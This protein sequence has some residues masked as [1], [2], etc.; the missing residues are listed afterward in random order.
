MSS[1]RHFAAILVTQ[2]VCVAV[3][4]VFH[5][6]LLARIGHGETGSS[7][8]P[9]SALWAAS[10]I[11]LVWTVGLLAATLFMTVTRLKP[12]NSA[13]RVNPEIEA[14]KQ[15]QALLRTQETVIFGLAKLS[16]SRDPETGRHLERI[17]Q[18]SS[19][20]AAALRQR[21]EFRDRITPGFLQLIGISSALHDIG[22]VGVEDSILRKPGAL[23]AEQR[24]RMQLHTQVG[25][26]CLKEIERQLGSTNFLQMACEIVSAHHEWW[27]G[28][29]YPRG[30]AGEEIPLSARIV[31][32]ADVYDALRSKRV[33]KSA[34]PHEECV[35][36]IADAAG[37]QF[38]PRVVEVFLQLEDRFRRLADQF[39][40]A[41]ESDTPDAAPAALALAASA[42]IAGA[43]AHA[44]FTQQLGEI[45]LRLPQA[46][47]SGNES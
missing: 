35:A 40:T 41:E 12:T 21:P 27:N 1:R 36:V 28:Q 10:G 13:G 3:G 46:D 45:P 8:L 2:T 17:A 24:A 42:P 23:T 34:L 32:V 15:A 22:K 31:A 30:L 9:D 26:E 47:S 18:F 38:D 39:L 19:M 44:A 25:T 37:T 43:D 7:G 4:L 5:H 16:D 29:G 20:L 11:T 14:L 6:L 33:Y